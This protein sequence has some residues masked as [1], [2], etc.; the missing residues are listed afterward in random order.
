[1]LKRGGR[2]GLLRGIEEVPKKL[3]ENFSLVP[4]S[5]LGAFELLHGPATGTVNEKGRSVVHGSEF[6]L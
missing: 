6:G 4:T 5:T 1:M 2:G 3:V